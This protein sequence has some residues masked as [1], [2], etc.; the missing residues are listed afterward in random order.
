[1]SLQY[2]A[3]PL[4]WRRASS[5]GISVPTGAY[6]YEPSLVTLMFWVPLETARSANAANGCA[7]VASCL[8][9]FAGDPIYAARR[10]H[11]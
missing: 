6:G 8:G 3:S 11:L 2:F 4:A 1:M 7:A 9:I 5:F 10:K